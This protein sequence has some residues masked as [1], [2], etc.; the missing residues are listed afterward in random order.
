MCSEGLAKPR[1]AL[2]DSL[3]PA[4]ILNRYGVKAMMLMGGRQISAEKFWL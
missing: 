2:A 3:T 4:N 1:V